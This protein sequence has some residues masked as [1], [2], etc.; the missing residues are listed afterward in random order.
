MELGRD[1]GVSE[2]FDSCDESEPEEND[3]IIVSDESCATKSKSKIVFSTE[4]CKWEK[5][6]SSII[7]EREK[8]IAESKIM[9]EINEAKEELYGNS[10]GGRKRI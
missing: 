1:D 4:P 10:Q 5:I 7:K 3:E 9:D 6:R 2:Y 8:A